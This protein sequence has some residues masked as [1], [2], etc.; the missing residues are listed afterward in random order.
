[1]Y[2]SC[3]TRSGSPFLR[4]GFAGRQFGCS[5][6]VEGEKENQSADFQ[7]W[8]GKKT[9]PGDLPGVIKGMNAQF[10]SISLLG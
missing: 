9:T 1:V 10:C 7:A 8:M 2:F 5:A 6:H 4:R 3:A